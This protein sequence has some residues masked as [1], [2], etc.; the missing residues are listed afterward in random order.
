MGY[1]NKIAAAGVFALMA[2]GASAATCTGADRSISLTSAT[3]TTSCY[4]Y[5]MGNV[6]GNI[7]HDP[8]LNGKSMGGNTFTLAPG[9]SVISS[10][11]LLDKSDASGEVKDGALTGTLSGGTEEP[12]KN[13]NLFGTFTLGDVS[14][15]S[16]L[17]IALKVGN[18]GEPGWAAFKV[19]SAGV[20]DF[21]VSPKQGGGLSHVNV[22]GIEDA[23]PAPVPLPASALLLLGGIGGIA[24]LRRR[25][26]A[27]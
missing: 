2:T 10:L 6:N 8:I 4:A 17:I 16:S 27:A 3:A 5:G 26:K 19:A 12:G 15:Y 22:Y 25:K 13:G 7:D 23:V 20:F 24:A 1:L 21:L 11:T 9:S 14:G 18:S